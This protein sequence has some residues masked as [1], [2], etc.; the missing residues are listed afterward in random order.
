MTQTAG[1]QCLDGMVIVILVP[2]HIEIAFYW[3]L[4]EQIINLFHVCF[5]IFP[6]KY[7]WN[8][9]ESIDER[10]EETMNEIVMVGRTEV[11][12]RCHQ[13]N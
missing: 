4:S 7:K 10:E 9:L 8:S 12:E 3:T 1:I 6:N 13:R 2:N 11:I 5:A